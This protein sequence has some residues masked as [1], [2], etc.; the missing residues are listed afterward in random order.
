ML[1]RQKRNLEEDLIRFHHHHHHHHH[2]QITIHVYQRFDE[3]Y[4]Q[5]SHNGIVD[6]KFA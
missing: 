5:L 4:W 1:V 2:H 6:W 3:H